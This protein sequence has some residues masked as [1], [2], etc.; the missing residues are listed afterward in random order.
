M[1]VG[2]SIH[3]S[4][5]PVFHGHVMC[6][7]SHVTQRKE[8]LRTCAVAKWAMA[9]PWSKEH[10]SSG[11]PFSRPR[12]SK[13]F[14][15]PTR[16]SLKSLSCVSQGMPGTPPRPRFALSCRCAP[17]RTTEIGSP[18]CVSQGTPHACVWSPGIPPPGY[19]TVCVSPGTA[20]ASVWGPCI[21]SQGIPHAGAASNNRDCFFSAS[22]G[23]P[24][25]SWSQKQTYHL[26]SSMDTKMKVDV[27]S[28]LNQSPH[29]I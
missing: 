5:Q 21:P 1:V 14:P 2:N 20:H 28:S 27:D 10:L 15:W 23:V 16:A 22:Q 4:G 12:I 7:M 11:D 6:D 25:T 26:K 24:H 3:D 18:V 13:A 9:R 29:E 17:A 19:I 8:R